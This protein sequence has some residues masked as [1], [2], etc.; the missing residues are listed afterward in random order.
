[1]LSLAAAVAGC[2]PGMGALV[3]SRWAETHRES[4]RPVGIGDGTAGSAAEV[5][6][7]RPGDLGV[8]EVLDYA[9]RPVA[10]V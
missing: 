8:G 2:M 4:P 10:G 5:A 7:D 1:M 9:V 6:A 3:R